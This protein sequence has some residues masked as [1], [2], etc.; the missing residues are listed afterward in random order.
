MNPIDLYDALD[1]LSGFDR[2]ADSR[3]GCGPIQTAGK[4]KT[5]LHRAPPK[6]ALSPDPALQCK[7]GSSGSLFAIKIA[8][9]MVVVVLR[10]KM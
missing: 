9:A 1:K 5:S 6:G 7:A 10:I 8:E 3:K 4:F 2:D